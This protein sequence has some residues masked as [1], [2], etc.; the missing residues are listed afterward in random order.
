M[1]VV[2]TLGLLLFPVFFLEL[3]VIMGFLMA[4]MS[5]KHISAARLA[6]AF[7][8]SLVPIAIAYHMAHYFS[9]LLIHGQRLIPL[10]SDPL[11][12]GW[13]LFG[14]AAYRLNIGIVGA[15]FAW[16]SAVIAII[17]GHVIAVSLAHLTAMR[18]LPDRALALRSQYPMLV[19]MVGYTIISLWILAQPIVEGG[20]HETANASREGRHADG[21]AVVSPLRSEIFWD[22]EVIK[23]GVTGG[24]PDWH[25]APVRAGDEL[26]VQSAQRRRR[27]ARQLCH[28]QSIVH[29]RFRA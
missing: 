29:R 21:T 2:R 19:L 25:T 6:R 24:V 26:P 10:L 22:S 13:D 23:G 9:F 14:T 12:S 27:L 28:F 4:V 18:L 5:G 20:E 3:Y 16:Y 15:R 11:G 8:F 7:T 17:I 1:T